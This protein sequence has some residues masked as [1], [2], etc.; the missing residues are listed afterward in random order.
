MIIKIDHLTISASDV[1]FNRYINFFKD[2]GYKL[3]FIEKDI[4]NL[5][6]KSKLTKDF[7]TQQSLALL[8]SDRNINIE[9]INHGN[10]FI[11]DSNITPVFENLPGKYIEKTIKEGNSS[12]DRRIVKMKYFDNPTYSLNNKEKENFNF[13][14]LI[15]ATNSIKESLKFWDIFGFKIIKENGDSAILE[16]NSFFKDS[17]CRINLET[18]ES[19][20]KEIFL[21]CSGFNCLAFVSNSAIKEKKRINGAGF[22]TTDIDS[23]RVNNKELDIFFVLGNQG[24]IAEVIS[25][26]R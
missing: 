10:Y 25:I 14:N 13:N 4:N 19:V 21:D 12:D 8:V 9:V 3:S 17:Y 26:K 11:G 6:I 23:L 24:E 18:S 16:F 22:K 1:K 15:I 20:N 2:L 7:N 5:S